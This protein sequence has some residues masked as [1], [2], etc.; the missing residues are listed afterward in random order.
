[1]S[2]TKQIS[3]CESE[4]LLETNHSEQSDFSE[5]NDDSEIDKNYHPE[6]TESSEEDDVDVFKTASALKV[7]VPKRRKANVPLIDAE[8]QVG[9]NF[10][11]WCVR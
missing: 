2:F 7:H 5:D 8:K 6:D 4:Q 3:E 11:K 1:M 9:R 10:L